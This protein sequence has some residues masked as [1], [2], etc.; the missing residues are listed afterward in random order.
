MAVSWDLLCT[1]DDIY[2]RQNRSEC[3]HDDPAILPPGESEFLRNERE[4][5]SGATC[6]HP[7]VVLRLLADFQHEISGQNDES[8]GRQAEANVCCVDYNMLHE[9]AV[10]DFT[11]I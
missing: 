4:P 6:C 7:T 8:I 11:R 2:A 3:D 5:N 1:R 10:G 9:S